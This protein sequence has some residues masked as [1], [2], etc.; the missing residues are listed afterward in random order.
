MKGNDCHR[1]TYLT[2]IVP[3][4]AP[5]NPLVDG[6]T[7][8]DFKHAC[9]EYHYMPSRDHLKK[10]DSIEVKIPGADINNE[11][12]YEIHEHLYSIFFNLFFKFYSIIKIFIFKHK[13][14]SYR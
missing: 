2:D 8:I 9:D 5:P 4:L 1:I 6:E 11:N 3:N 12:Y 10:L 13:I 14:N 7:R